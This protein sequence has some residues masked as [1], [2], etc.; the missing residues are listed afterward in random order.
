MAVG[1]ATEDRTLDICSGLYVYLGVMHVSHLH[2]VGI[3]CCRETSATT[4]DETAVEALLVGIGR[5][6]DDAALDVYLSFTR[7]VAVSYLAGAG[8]DSLIAYRCQRAAAEDIVV[9]LTAAHFYEGVAIHTSCS[10]RIIAITI[11]VNS[12]AAAI[13]VASIEESAATVVV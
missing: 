4:I 3:R 12:S 9:N 7:I 10:Q 1:T 13:D 6:T 2:D 5:V 8:V 11:G